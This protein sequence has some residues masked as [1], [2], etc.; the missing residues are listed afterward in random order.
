MFVF[1]MIRRP[2]RSTRTDTPF[3]Y[4]TLFRS[5]LPREEQ[6]LQILAQ[7][8]DLIGREQ[9][10]ADML[11]SERYAGLFR[12]DRAAHA[13]EHDRFLAEQIGDELGAVVIVD[14]EYL[15]EAGVR[16]EGAGAA[17][18]ERAR[19]EGHTSE[20]QS[21]TRHSSAAFRLRSQNH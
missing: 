5:P 21:L 7:R 15:Q 13:L 9:G 18:V 11:R 16:Q 10:A 20:L 14:A 1:L 6:E 19:R 4:T 2:P 12:V 3:P 17:P 8:A